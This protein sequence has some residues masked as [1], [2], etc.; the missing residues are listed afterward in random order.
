MAKHNVKFHQLSYRDMEHLRQVW[1]RDRY[2]EVH[3]EVI[4]INQDLMLF[5]FLFCSPLTKLLPFATRL[6]Y[7]IL[8]ESIRLF[9]TI[10][11]FQSYSPPQQSSIEFGPHFQIEIVNT[12]NQFF[13][14]HI[15][16]C[17]D[18]KGNRKVIFGSDSSHFG[19]E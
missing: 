8:N 2:P 4:E 15:K 16:I 18:L 7:R 11:F 10:G 17:K 12:K 1:S 19:A 14:E 3:G 9:V 13:S 6:K 5:S